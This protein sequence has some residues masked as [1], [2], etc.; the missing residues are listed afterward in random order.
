MYSQHGYL[1]YMCNILCSTTAF[2]KCCTNNLLSIPHQNWEEIRNQ[3][4]FGQHS[5]SYAI[6]II[7]YNVVLGIIVISENICTTNAEI[8]DSCQPLYHLMI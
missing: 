5:D 8:G 1:S 4:P 3:S 6:I 7:V 2:L